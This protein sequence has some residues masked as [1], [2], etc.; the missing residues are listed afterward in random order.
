MKLI[1]ILIVEDDNSLLA[2]LTTLYRAKFAERGFTAT[3]ETAQTVD[4][5]RKL[6]KAAQSH[7][8]DLVSLDVILGDTSLTGLNV[9]STLKRFESAW[10]VALVT[11]VETDKNA[12][13]TLGPDVAN[14]LRR[15]LRKEAYTRFPAERLLVV[16]KPS[17]QLDEKAATTL[18]GNRLEQIALV[19]EEVGRLRYIFR[20]VKVVSL[21]RVKTGNRSRAARQFVEKESRHWQI[22]FNCGDIRTLP[23]KAG[24][25]TL[26]KLLGLSP[27]ESLTPEEALLLEPVKRKAGASAATEDTVATYFISKGFPWEEMDEPR[28]LE[29]IRAALTLKF[30]RYCE[31]RGF[32]ADDDLS[33]NEEDELKAIIKDLGPLAGLAETA[34]HRLNPDSTEAGQGDDLNIGGLIQQGLNVQRGGFREQEEGRLG[35][36]SLDGEAF[37]A[38]KKRILDDLRENGFAAMADHLEIHLQSLSSNWSYDPPLG[39]EWT[40]S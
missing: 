35:V 5:A 37:R 28:R 34:Y 9:L 39:V 38:R 25:L 12:D 15:Q 20:P 4:E 8:Y 14:D 27:G 30:E 1:R 29:T 19:Y 13:K 40:V 11:G 2:K 3:I 10:M 7:P 16:E 21:E 18:L 33:P 6:A 23:D 31:L 26:H 17:Q 22:R 32:Q 24:Y 36:D